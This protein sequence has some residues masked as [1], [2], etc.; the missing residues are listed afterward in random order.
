[1]KKEPF[2]RGI[3]LNWDNPEEIDKWI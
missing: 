2:K 1:M 3:P